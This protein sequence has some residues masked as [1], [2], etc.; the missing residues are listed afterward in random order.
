L[1]VFEEITPE[2]GQASW[3]AYK[4]CDCAASPDYPKGTQ[5]LVSLPDDPDSNITVVVNDY[6]PERDIFPNRVIDLDSTA[7]K[8]L[9]PLSLGVIDIRV[10]LLQ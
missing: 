6:G 2:Y 4:G 7:F 3:Y 8:K 10:Q 5:L 1:A 9:A